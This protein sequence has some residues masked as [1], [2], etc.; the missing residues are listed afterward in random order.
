[1]TRPG[2]VVALGVALGIAGAAG[3]LWLIRFGAVASAPLR[4]MLSIAIAMLIGV[5]AGTTGKRDGVK[6][7]AVMGVV[8]G[9]ILTVVG[10]GALL[11]D[12]A[13]VGLNPM[14]STESFLVFASSIMAGTIIAS[15]IVAGVAALVAWPLSLAPVPEDE[16]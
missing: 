3:Q 14:A 12:P 6:A 11:V 2:I 8:A 16:A 5:I 7:A 9:A 13:L 10:L 1:M 15:W 4:N